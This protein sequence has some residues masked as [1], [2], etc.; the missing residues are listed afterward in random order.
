M[1]SEALSSMDNPLE[2]LSELIDFEMFRTDLEAIMV[3][4]EGK[5]AAGRPRIDVVMMFLMRR[6]SGISVI[7]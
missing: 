3:N 4:P 7:G 1:V 2:C 6:P 5:S